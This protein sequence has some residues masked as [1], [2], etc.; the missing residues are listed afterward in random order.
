MVYL[1]WLHHI[2]VKTTT[3][4]KAERGS[5]KHVILKT[6]FL[7]FDINTPAKTSLT[8]EKQSV[9]IYEKRRKYSFCLTVYRI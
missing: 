6:E 3:L 5:R 8:F 2:V 4:T 7:V 1:I 9:V